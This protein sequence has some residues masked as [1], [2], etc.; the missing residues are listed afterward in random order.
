MDYKN[1]PYYRVGRA[2][3]LSGLDRFIYRSLE[4]LPGALSWATILGTIFL[5]YFLPFWAAIFIIV[6]DLYWLLKTIYLSVY[7]RQNWQR[8]K[9]N[10]SVDWKKRL[11][12]LKYDQIYHTVILPFYNEDREVLEKSLEAL[13]NSEYDKNKIIVILASEERGGKRAENLSKTLEK[14]YG[15]LFAYFLRTKHPMGIFGEMP[16]KGS[17]I[18]YAAEELRKKILDKNFIKYED[19]I[20]SA[21]DIDTIIYPQ[22]FECLTWNFLTAEE[23]LKSSFQ[24]VPFYHNN[25]WQSPALSRVVAL[26]G[27]FWQMV[28]QERPER[29]STFSSHAISFKALF[30]IGYWQR[31]MVSEDSRIFWNAFFVKNGDYHVIP[32]SYPVS[33]DANLDESFWQTVKSIY[34]QQRRWAWGVENLPYVFF[35]FLKNDKIAWQKKIHFSFILLEGFWSWS[36]SPIMIFLLGWLPVILGGDVFQSSLL[37]YNLPI[38]TRNLMTLAMMGLVT[39]A[40]ISL[41]FLPTRPEGLSWKHTLF[42]I[43][44]WIFVPLT[45]T[46]FGAVPALDAQTRMMFGRYMGFWV[47]PKKRVMS[48]SKN[49]DD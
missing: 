36:T 9:H 7:L 18:A 40:M 43:C 14:K 13:V 8:T 4:I 47:T 5:S 23:P 12:N 41:S 19:V 48:K 11:E 17:N 21:F 29:L 35:G 42:M 30:D 24:P 45:V 32:M 31:N 27:T 28:Q 20:V 34:K 10:L 39:S 1:S 46:I 3:D 38:F 2:S 26:S 49:I 15:H 16:G 44:Q 6:F 25:I 37:S 22:Y 33:M